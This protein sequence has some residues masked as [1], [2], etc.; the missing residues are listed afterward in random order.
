MSETET[1]KSHIRQLYVAPAGREDVTPPG[2]TDKSHISRYVAPSGPKDPGGMDRGHIKA[3]Y[4]TPVPDPEDEPEPDPVLVARL[5]R[6]RELA[7]HAEL[8][9]QARE[10]DRKRAAKSV[11]PTSNEGQD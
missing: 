9:R 8:V 3:L 1:D 2:E 11:E 7:A 10:Q 5:E 4:V 6:D